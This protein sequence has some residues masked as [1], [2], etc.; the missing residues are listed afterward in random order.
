MSDPQNLRVTGSIQC[1]QKAPNAHQDAIQI[2]GGTNITFVNVEAG[3]NYD[4]GTSTC[5]GAGGGPFYSLNTITNVDVLGG[6]YIACNHTLNGHNA[7]SGPGNDVI[8]AR[9]RSGRSSDP[10]CE[11]IHASPPCMNTG[12]LALFQN[13]T[14]QQWLGGRWVDVPPR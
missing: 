2:Q 13:A 8:Q 9:F 11:G 4:A 1:G 6:K 14:C 10:N 12:A 7:D 3:G 5:A